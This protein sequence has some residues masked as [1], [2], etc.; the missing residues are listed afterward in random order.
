MLKK[1]F[2]FE[3][4][5]DR[6]IVVI[7]V[8]STL[9]IMIDS[10]HNFTGYKAL[11]RVIIYMVVPML[12]IIFAERRSPKEYGFQW[13]DWKAGLAI[14]LLAIILIAPVLYF[15]AKGDPAMEKYYSRQLSSVTPIF[16]FIDLIGWEFIFR[17]WIL[18]GYQRKFGDHALWLHAV[19]FALGHLGKPEFETLSTI[20]GGFLF[21]LVAWRTKS[22]IYPFL[23]HWFVAT[24]TILVAGG[25]FG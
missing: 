11:D 1:L 5:F 17:G 16:T 12:I 9:L 3:L 24:F 21:G 8:V 19:P 6:D 4:N 2:N 7:T 15:V 10:Y 25:A 14:T 18:F 20:F 13:G 22:F 23:I